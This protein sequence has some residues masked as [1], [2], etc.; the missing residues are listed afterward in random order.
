V[1]EFKINVEG[2]DR[3]P[4]VK[5]RRTFGDIVKESRDA[6]VPTIGEFVERVL[7]TR[8]TQPQRDMLA[9]M[10]SEQENE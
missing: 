4:F 6:G 8:L 10:A 9:D 7:G 2:R 1:K 5:S 3:A